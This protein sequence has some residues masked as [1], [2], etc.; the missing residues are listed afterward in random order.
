RNR[1]LNYN[2]ALDDRFSGQ[3]RGLGLI[4]DGLAR[5]RAGGA[6]AAQ[7]EGATLDVLRLALLVARPL[8]EVAD[9]PHQVGEA[10]LICVLP[11]RPPGCHPGL[12]ARPCRSREST[13]DPPHAPTPA[14]ARQETVAAARRHRPNLSPARLQVWAPYLRSARAAPPCGR[15]RLP[16]P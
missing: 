12:P 10:E 4:D 13:R 8:D 6:G 7:R 3:D 5:D 2:R 16:S 14:C 1:I 15:P 9:W 11:P